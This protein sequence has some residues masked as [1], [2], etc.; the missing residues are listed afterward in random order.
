MTAYIRLTMRSK[1]DVKADIERE[2]YKKRGNA[3]G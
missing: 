3:G 1:S 2:A